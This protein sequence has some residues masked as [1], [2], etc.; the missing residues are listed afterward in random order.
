MH[1]TSVGGETRCKEHGGEIQV[2]SAAP[3]VPPSF[4][5]INQ[6]GSTVLSSFIPVLLLGYSVQVMLPSFVVLVSVLYL[7]HD[8]AH[9]A[10]R[11]ID[12]ASR[13]PMA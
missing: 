9:P 3:L 6:S 13:D 8:S 11:L 5:Y 1:A 7:P 2:Q 12:V 4:T 10:V